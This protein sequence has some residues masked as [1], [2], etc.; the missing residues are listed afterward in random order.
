MY[1]LIWIKV[2]N[3]V[4]HF[5]KLRSLQ[6]IN[7]DLCASSLCTLCAWACAVDQAGL[8]SPTP[9]S[10]AGC[11]WQGSHA[12]ARLPP[13]QVS[14][15]LI[16]TCMSMVYMKSLTL[17]AMVQHEPA[18]DSGSQSFFLSAVR[19]SVSVA[20][21]AKCMTDTHIAWSTSLKLA[22]RQLPQ[23]QISDIL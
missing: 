6:R 5:S 23:L 19:G 14:H 21:L 11:Y 3:E 2:A 17:E 22:D 9:G 10:Q 15:V 1:L 13:C 8:P 16:F 12:R 18:D 4:P 7:P 20:R